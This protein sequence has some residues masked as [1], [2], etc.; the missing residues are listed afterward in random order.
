MSKLVG[1]EEGTA[2]RTAAGTAPAAQTVAAAG[3]G[4]T[5]ISDASLYLEVAPEMKPTLIGKLRDM[6]LGDDMNVIIKG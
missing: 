3:G 1:M 4:T 5:V 2:A 6:V